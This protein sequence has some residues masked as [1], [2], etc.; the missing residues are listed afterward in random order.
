MT[1]HRDCNSWPKNRDGPGEQRRGEQ[2]W[3]TLPQIH[4]WKV[5]LAKRGILVEVTTAK[6]I[7]TNMAV[8]KSHLNEFQKVRNMKC[9]NICIWFLL[10]SQRPSQ[11]S[12]LE[13]HL[14]LLLG[15]C[16]WVRQELEIQETVR[17]WVKQW[18]YFLC[19]IK[20]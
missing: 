5:L 6:T 20:L 7:S 9:H 17:F 18:F 19:F 2:L 16:S 15:Q 13:P 1:G 12:F 11:D 14:P 3:R 4:L 10:P 8:F